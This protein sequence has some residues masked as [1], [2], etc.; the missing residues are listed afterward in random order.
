MV[1][2]SRL[3]VIGHTLLLAA[4]L[5]ALV[6]CA[7][8]CPRGDRAVTPEAPVVTATE[9][10]PA[11]ASLPEASLPEASAGT[12]P[13]GAPCGPNVGSCDAA[14]YCAF[15]ADAACGDRAVAG[16]CTARTRGCFKDCPGVC[17][18][19]GVRYCNTCVAQG[20]GHSVRHAGSCEVAPADPLTP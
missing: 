18:C 10:V 15:P 13:L 9:V 8:A 12:I 19:D 1:I 5:C 20:R 17:G 2:V 4:S 16:V 3:S 11:D 7:G 6:A 14:G